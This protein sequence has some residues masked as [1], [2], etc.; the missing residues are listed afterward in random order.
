MIPFLLGMLVVAQ[1]IPEQKQVTALVAQIRRLAASEPVV[2]GIDTRL[3]TAEVL[4]GKYP[5]IARDLLRESQAALGGVTS[6]D[7]QDSMRVHVVELMAPLDLDE[8]EHVIASIHR[9]DEEDYVA[10]AYDQLVAFLAG[11]HRDTREMISKGLQAGGFRSGSA[12]KKLEDSKT[13]NPAVAVSVFAEILG[14]FPAQSAGEKDVYYMLVNTKLI[15]DLNRSLAL[16]AIDKA[17]SAAVSEKLRVSRDARLKMLREI[18]ALVGSI[19][20]DLLQQY[21]TEHKE[22][23]EAALAQNIPAPEKEEKQT[24]NTPDL[25]GLSYSD[26]LSRAESL[27]D[28]SERVLAL[29]EIYRRESITAQQR[30]SVASQALS[31]ANQMPVLG[32]R[33]VAMAMIS[34]D[35]ARRGELA[36]AAFAAQL[37]SETYSKACACERATCEH[38][39][40]SLDCLGMVED[41]AKYLDEFKISPESMNLNNI[42]LE[43]RLLI[44]KLYPLVGLKTPTLFF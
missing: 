31:A 37:L 14:A 28:V 3:R 44:L 10:Q 32:D 4:T 16:E 20:P 40:E 12:A 41:F 19:D 43:A 15:A 39:G 26:A 8:A 2:Y 18:A 27:E 30:S 29:I 35:F 23:I 11:N 22:L 42:S 25:S 9:G 5:R 1:Q 33:L 38:A 21:K 13:S 17:L 36:N 24:L 6:A 34:R 7:E